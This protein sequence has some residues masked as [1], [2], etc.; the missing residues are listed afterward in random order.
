M[1]YT[2]PVAGAKLKADG[3]NFE[4]EGFWGYRHIIE[5]NPEWFGRYNILERDEEHLLRASMNM[6]EGI[7]HEY[8]ITSVARQ[9]QFF[10]QLVDDKVLQYQER[11]SKEQLQKAFEADDFSDRIIYFYCHGNSAGLNEDPALKVAHIKLTDRQPIDDSD[12]AL[13]LRAQPELKTHPLIFIN[14]CK[15]G[16]MTTMFF[17]TFAVE[18]LKQRARGLIGAQIDIPAEFAAEYAQRLFSELL[19]SPQPPE[20]KI[21]LGPLMSQLTRDFIDTYRNPLGLI[22]SLYRGMDV[23]MDRRPRETQ[24]S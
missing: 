7:D 9:R 23:Y 1:I 15:G 22:Y 17:K 6:D 3:S 13:W 8:N 24:A 11:C 21:R 12:I 20:E 19:K 2:H 4:W 10:A 16:Q 5:H 14:A 18:F